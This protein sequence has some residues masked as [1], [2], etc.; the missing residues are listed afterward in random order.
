MSSDVPEM[1]Q[2]TGELGYPTTEEIFKQR[3]E[4]IQADPNY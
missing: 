4:T 3:M 1:T 2:L